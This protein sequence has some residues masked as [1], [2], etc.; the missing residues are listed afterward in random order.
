MSALVLAEEWASDE[1]LQT[2]L[3][4]PGFAAFVEVIR[5]AVAELPTITRFGD[6]TGRPLLSPSDS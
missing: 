2:H 6:A 5:P 4:S 3:S 1:A